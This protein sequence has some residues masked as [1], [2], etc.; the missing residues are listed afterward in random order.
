MIS[1][2]SF[3]QWRATFCS[4]QRLFCYSLEAELSDTNFEKCTCL[5]SHRIIA[6]FRCTPALICP[7]C[8]SSS[9]FSLSYHPPARLFLPPPPLHHTPRVPIPHFP[10]NHRLPRGFEALSSRPPPMRHTYKSLSLTDIHTHIHTH[11]FIHA[12]TNTNLPASSLYPPSPFLSQM[13]PV[14]RE[15][16]PCAPK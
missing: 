9:T 12:H 16:P 11:S 5:L 8:S 4:F 7:F 13:W 3:D 15:N 2:N 6:S 1:N 10:P 14:P